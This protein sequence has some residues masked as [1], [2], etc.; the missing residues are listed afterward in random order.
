MIWINIFQKLNYFI[1]LQLLLTSEQTIGQSIDELIAGASDSI[2]GYDIFMDVDA[3]SIR[4][5]LDMILTAEQYKA[6]GVHFFFIFG[7]FCYLDKIS[8]I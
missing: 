4:T 6:L 8:D 1:L 3:K 5:E 7:Q 2:G